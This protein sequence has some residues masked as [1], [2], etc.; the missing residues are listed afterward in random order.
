MTA[1]ATLVLYLAVAFGSLL[2]GVLRAAVSLAALAWLGDGFPWATLAVNLLGSLAIGCYA[3]LTGPAG[4]YS[5]SL[6]QRQFVMA[7]FCGG[8]TTFSAFSLETLQLLQGQRMAAAGLYIGLSVATWLA[9]VWLGDR[10][11]RRPPAA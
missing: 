11:G 3:A 8:F 5:V 1:R 6:R 10:L 7:G 9:A 4:R 2:G